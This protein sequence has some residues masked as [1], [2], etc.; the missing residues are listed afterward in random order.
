MGQG[1]GKMQER[2]Q[3]VQTS[4]CKISHRDVLYIMMTIINNTVLHI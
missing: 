3:K 4:S 1:V 2:G